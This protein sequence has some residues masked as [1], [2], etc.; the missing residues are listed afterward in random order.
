MRGRQAFGNTWVAQ[1]CMCWLLKLSFVDTEDTGI[2]DYGSLYGSSVSVLA[3]LVYI[4]I[5]IYTYIFS[6]LQLP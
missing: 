2:E 5:Y 4:Y 1:G 6:D 3:P